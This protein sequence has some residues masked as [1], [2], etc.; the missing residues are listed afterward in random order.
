[1]NEQER[2]AILSKILGK[3]SDEV[4][5]KIVTWLKEQLIMN[6]EDHP[7]AAISVSFSI[8]LKTN[9]LVKALT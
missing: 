1:M 5:Q 4:A 3:T 2:E 7:E 6:F 8:K 9:E